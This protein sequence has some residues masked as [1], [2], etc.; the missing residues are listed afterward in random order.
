MLL[1]FHESVFHFCLLETTYVICVK[2]CCCIPIDSTP[3]TQFFL[4]KVNGNLVIYSPPIYTGDLLVTVHNLQQKIQKKEKHG[5]HLQSMG[6]SRF[7]D[8]FLLQT[9]SVKSDRDQ[10]KLW[11]CMKIDPSPTCIK[12][13]LYFDGSL[14]ERVKHSKVFSLY[15]KA[16]PCMEGAFINWRDL[17][18]CDM[19]S[20]YS[21][22]KRP[23]I[24]FFTGQALRFW[25]SSWITHVQSS[26]IVMLRLL[27]SM[28]S[29]VISTE[30]KLMIGN[31]SVARKNCSRKSSSKTHYRKIAVEEEAARPI[32][33]WQKNIAE[34]SSCLLFPTAVG[35][36]AECHVTSQTDVVN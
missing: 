29:N 3:F 1:G 7:L 12:I 25:R 34:G 10:Q 22:S 23:C 8:L 4:L 32:K 33:A 11:T 27:W 5:F 14:S 2:C 18:A 15:L 17:L 35:S 9:L 13:L 20:F 24:L 26:F 21:S 36:A 30:L 31:C 28:P 16:P 6:L 19:Q